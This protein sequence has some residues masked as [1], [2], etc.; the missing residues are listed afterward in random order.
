MT[1]LPF[2]TLEARAV[3]LVRDDIDTDQIIP[4][5]F[6]T[7]ISRAGLGRH[8]FADWR[9]DSMNAPRP[10]FPLNAP[11]AEGARVL[12]AGRNFGC[13]SSREHASWAL[14]DWGFRVII[15]TSFADIF[16]NNA[17][18]NGLLTIALGASDHRALLDV[19]EGDGSATL[20]VDLAAQRVAAGNWSAS[21]TIEPFAKRC[22]LEGVDELGFLLAVDA[23]IAAFEVRHTPGVAAALL[24]ASRAAS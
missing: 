15:A 12:V 8:L 9:C 24:T 16:R 22:L 18:K 21:F 13:G 20:H 1:P 10:D 5:R 6:L 11:A 14:A 23:D 19:L 2:T 17:S 3:R 4:A 7:T